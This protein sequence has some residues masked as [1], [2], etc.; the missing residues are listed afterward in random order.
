[1]PQR[2][3]PQAINF[4][5]SWVT[6]P[7]QQRE[8]KS[9]KCRTISVHSRASVSSNRA[10]RTKMLY[11][12]RSCT[13]AQRQARRYNRKVSTNKRHL[14]CQL[15]IWQLQRSLILL[16]RWSL[17]SLMP[18]QIILKNSVATRSLRTGRHCIHDMY[19]SANI[20]RAIRL[21]MG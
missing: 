10:L 16:V 17:R 11:D 2:M 6:D 12:T 14:M 18:I 5:R 15:Y 13:L 4:P 3:V 20:I 19:C 21:R 7:L 8:W 9:I 1:M